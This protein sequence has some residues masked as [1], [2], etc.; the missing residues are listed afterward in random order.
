MPSGAATMQSR[1]R[2][3]APASRRRSSA[4]IGAAARGEHRVD[5]Q[6]PRVLEPDRELRVVLR[7]HGR[8]FVALEADVAD[9]GAGQEIEHRLEHAQPGSQHGH[10]HDLLADPRARR[11]PE[12]RLDGVRTPGQIAGGLEGEDEAHAPCQLPE[13]VGR[14]LLVAE[15]QQQVLP[16]GVVDDVNRHRGIKAQ[17]ERRYRISPCHT[18]SRSSWASSSPWRRPSPT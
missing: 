11:G 18:G 3:R 15:R 8:L 10:D 13:L 2:S 14:G 1:W 7:G 12:R 9:A 4:K 5:H 17:G 6:D 16:E